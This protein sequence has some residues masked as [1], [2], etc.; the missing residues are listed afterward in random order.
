MVPLNLWSANNRKHP[1][2]ALSASH[3]R[4]ALRSRRKWTYIHHLQRNCS[5]GTGNHRIVLHH[6]DII[7][8]GTIREERVHLGENSNKK[9]RIQTKSKNKRNS[10]FRDAVMSTLCSRCPFFQL[11][12]RIR[13]KN[14]RKRCRISPQR[15]LRI[16]RCSD[17]P[18]KP[19]LNQPQKTT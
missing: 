14:A 1:D 2:R 13:R 15:D 9:V 8:T 11:A 19:A 5:R 3:L 18:E 16:N 17:F 6:Y 7:G 12:P 10:E 4:H